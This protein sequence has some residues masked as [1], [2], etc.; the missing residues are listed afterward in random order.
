MAGGAVKAFGIGLLGA[1]IGVVAVVIG[2]IAIF[3]FAIIGALVGAVTG[4]ILNLVPVLGPLTV[5]GFKAVGIQSPDLVALG[6]MLGFVGGFFKS[7][8]HGGQQC[9]GD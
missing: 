5:Q 1:V 2:I 3:F 9:K 6:A 7:N 8:L 4:F